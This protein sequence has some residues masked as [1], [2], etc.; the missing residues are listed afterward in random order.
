MNE[1]LPKWLWGLIVVTGVISIGFLDYITGYELNFFVFYFVPVA[2]AAWFLGLRASV[3]VSLLSAIV[4][5]GADQLSGNPHSQH[6]YAVWNTII[7]LVSFV[8]I[9]SLT[10]RI[11]QLIDRERQLVED[12]QQSISEVK[13]LEAFLP[14][15]SQCKKIRNQEGSWQQLEVYISEHS[16]TKF[17]HGYC[18]ECAKK[19]IE[20]AGLLK[21]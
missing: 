7:R 4:W 2:L 8:V 10:S 5:F 13:V 21:K 9:G 16:D 1:Y 6:F 19:A 11:R 15:C 18:P 14:I 12:L 3:Y 20:E 17:S